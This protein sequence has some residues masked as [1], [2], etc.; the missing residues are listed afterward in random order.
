MKIIPANGLR[1]F[2]IIALYINISIATIHKNTQKEK[3]SKFKFLAFSCSIW[4]VAIHT[5][6]TST[7]HPSGHGFFSDFH[8]ANTK[9]SKWSSNP[10][11]F[12]PASRIFF[13]LP[14]LVP[15]GK[16]K[17]TLLTASTFFEL[18]L[19]RGNRWVRSISTW[20]DRFSTVAH[21]KSYELPTFSA[22][23]V[24]CRSLNLVAASLTYK[25]FEKSSEFCSL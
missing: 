3:Q 22:P 1:K 5:I 25:V 14:R 7:S 8:R 15:V 20:S 4:S 18:P 10:Y 11:Y 12:Y 23:T 17:K 6:N 24:T 16:R 2:D 9:V 13:D 21:D 19:I